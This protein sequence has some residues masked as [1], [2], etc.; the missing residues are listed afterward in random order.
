[1][2]EDSEVR[3]LLGDLD[4][5]E[6]RARL[7]E[8]AD[9]VADYRANIADRPVAQSVSPGEIGKLLDSASWETG[10]SLDDIMY[11][12]DRIVMPGIV[13]WGHPAFLGYFGSTSN[14]PAL[15]GEIAAAALNVSAMTWKTSPAATEMETVVVDRIRQMIGVDPSFTGIVYDTA[16]ISTLHALAAARESCGDDIRRS[17]M[18]NREMPTLRIYVS[19]QGHTSVAKSAIILGI[20]ESNVVKVPTT[21]QF[22]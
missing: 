18:A 16:S 10:A 22:T 7:H 3:A 20:G 13:N 17:G 1:M 14:G 4:P 8:M 19:D 15:L 9:W 11:D 6:M 21:A 5:E 12:L 2:T